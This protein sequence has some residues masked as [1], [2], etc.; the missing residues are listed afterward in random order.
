[1][2]QR[3]YS[4]VAPG[5]VYER[6]TVLEEAESRTDRKGK[7]LKMWRCQCTCGTI[8]TVYGTSLLRG[9]SR[10]CGCW[11]L[12]RTSESH[13]KHGGV[14]T[15]EYHSWA[16]LK[17]RCLCPNDPA[18][19][20]Y[21]GRGIG[22][23]ESWTGEHGFE[24]FLADMGKRPSPLHSIDRIDNNSP[25]GYCKENCRWATKSEQANNRI[26]NHSITFSGETKTI[27]E[28]G[29]TPGYPCS[30]IIAHRLFRG[31]SIERALTQ[32]PRKSPSIQ[33]SR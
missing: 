13:W 31:W 30:S 6:W 20:R 15:E 5:S 28:W 9:L 17:S 4:P 11:R 33:L 29:R 27:A 24:H 8:S 21:G 19:S 22:V 2:P 18:Y 10:S 16:S 14:N 1:M 26:S 7:I 32:P 23:T 12:E 25:L 3:K